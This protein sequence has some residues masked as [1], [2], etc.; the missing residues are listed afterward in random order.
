MYTMTLL[1]RE[2]ESRGGGGVVWWSYLSHMHFQRR[3]E[4]LAANRGMLSTANV[5]ISHVRCCGNVI[6]VKNWQQ[7]ALESAMTVGGTSRDWERGTDNSYCNNNKLIW[8]PCK[9]V[10]KCGVCIWIQQS[11]LTLHSIHSL[12]CFRLDKVT[13]VACPL[14]VSMKRWAIHPA[15]ALL[16]DKETYR[17]AVQGAIS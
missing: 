9:K 6:N 7:G 10:R 1:S 16:P 13:P 5:N 8:K 3:G 17:Q 14:S 15:R 2:S 11:Q 4:T 12:S